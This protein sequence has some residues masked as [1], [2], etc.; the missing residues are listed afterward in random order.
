MSEVALSKCAIEKKRWSLR[1]ISLVL[2]VL[3]SMLAHSRDHLGKWDAEGNR[4][5]VGIG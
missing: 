3:V 1:A 5:P 2:M 4:F